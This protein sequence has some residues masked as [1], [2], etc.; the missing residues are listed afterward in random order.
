MVWGCWGCKGL[1]GCCPSQLC[2]RPDAASRLLGSCWEECP[3]LLRVPQPPPHL[4][5]GSRGA[6]PARWGMSHSR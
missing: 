5:E 2:Q 1:E 3:C 4:G 6:L